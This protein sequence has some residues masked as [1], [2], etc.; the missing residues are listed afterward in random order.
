DNLSIL[1]HYMY[2]IELSKSF[3]YLLQNLE[4]IL[5]NAINNELIKIESRWLHNDY[6]LEQQEINKIKKIKNSSNLTHDEIIASLDF[7]FYARLFDNK[8]ERKI[9]H[10]IIRKVFPNIEKYKRNRSYISGRIHKFR[11][12][13]NRIAHH[14]PIYYWNNIPQYHDEIIEFI[15]WI[16]KDMKEFT[17]QYDNFYEIVKTNIKEI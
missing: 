7:G 13:R 2:N 1:E 12:L 15:G 8:Y 14:K 6:F 17:L 10:R 9:W 5:R 11:I 4:I 3:Y 16:N